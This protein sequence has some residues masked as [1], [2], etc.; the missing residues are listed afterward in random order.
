MPRLILILAA[1]V[2]LAT[3]ARCASDDLVSS[4]RES[5]DVVDGP[6]TTEPTPTT[7]APP[8][9][10]AAAAAAAPAPAAPAAKAPAR[11]VAAA[12]TTVA[13]PAGADLTAVTDPK[14]GKP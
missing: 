10:A 7:S 12:P 6:S 1:L 8:A 9:P 11:P 4:A 14:L 3:L 13:P 2:G 5:A